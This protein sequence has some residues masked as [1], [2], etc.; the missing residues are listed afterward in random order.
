MV[1]VPGCGWTAE[2]R[3][4]IV[5]VRKVRLEASTVVEVVD[6]DGAPVEVIGRFL[7]HLAARGCSPNTVASYAYDLLHLW[8]FLGGRNLEWSDMRPSTSLDLLGRPT[9]GRGNGRGSAWR[10]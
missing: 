10:P 5:R 6:D 8:R 3:E 1:A 4:A 2:P 7:R 9:R